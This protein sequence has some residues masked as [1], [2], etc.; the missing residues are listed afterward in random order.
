MTWSSVPSMG[1]TIGLLALVACGETTTEPNVAGDLPSTAPDFAVAANTWITRADLPSTERYRLA[2]ATVTNSAGQSV[3]YVIG[4]NTTGGD[5]EAFGGSLSKVQAYNVA[6]NSW[7][8]KASLPMPLYSTNGAGVIN[9]KIYVSGGVTAYNNHRKELYRY[10]PASNTW[11]RKH[12]MPHPAWRGVTGVINNKLYV[13]PGCDQVEQDGCLL[14]TPLAFYRYDPVTDQWSNLPTPP[15]RRIDGV[16]GVIGG[17]L[18]VAGGV[19]GTHAV[20]RLD[21]FDPATNQWTSK[22]PMPRERFAAAGVALGGKLYV[23]GGRRP[24]FTTV[25]TTLVYDPGSDS[26]T[27]KSQDPS[28]RADIAATRVVFNGQ[29]RIELVGGPRPGNNLQYVP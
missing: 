2:A 8:Y 17:K 24:S 19:D 28:P 4:G 21:V 12:D 20:T 14:G 5:S 16:A 10:D 25:G 11:T 3:V 29:A 7:T 18:Y 15:G 26:W 1:F 13:L 22:A 6:T 9:G 23:I 27:I